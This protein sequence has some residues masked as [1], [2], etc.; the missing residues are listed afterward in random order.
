MAWFTY[1]QHPE[2]PDWAWG[3][4]YR[5]ARTELAR[6]VGLAYETPGDSAQDA[7]DSIMFAKDASYKDIGKTLGDINRARTKMFKVGRLISLRS[8]VREK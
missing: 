1:V 2:A 3:E 5:L 6:R 4:V 7:W 8:P